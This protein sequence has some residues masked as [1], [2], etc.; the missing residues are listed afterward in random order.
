[1]GKRPARAAAISLAILAVTGFLLVRYVFGGPGTARPHPPALTAAAAVKALATFDKAFYVG[2]WHRGFYSKSTRTGLSRL[3]ERGGDDRDGRGLL[4]T[5]RR[6][7]LQAAGRRPVPRS[8]RAIRHPDGCTCTDPTSH[9]RIGQRA[10]DDIMWM[11]IA[12][13]RAY[14]ITGSA[15]YL[16]M[17]RWNFDHAYARAWS[18]ALGGGLWWRTANDR[19]GRTRRRTR[20]AVIAAGELYRAHQRPRLSC[21]GDG[22]LHMDASPPVRPSD[23]GRFYDIVA[24]ADDRRHQRSSSVGYTYNQGSFIGAADLLYA[25]TRRRI[26]YADALGALLYTRTHLTQDGIL[27]NDATEPDQ[28]AGGFKGVFARWALDLHAGQPHLRFDSWFRLNA[29]TGLVGAERRRP[30]RLGLAGQ[31]GRRAAVLL[32]LLIGRGHDGGRCWSLAPP[33]RHERPAA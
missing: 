14:T 2:S 32:G 24:P 28:D 12:F 33:G 22:A 1:M 31:D 17:A 23:S 26:Y 5:D 20:P 8:D 19:P 16:D 25:I 9:R 13:T 3:L 27:Q 30:R 21:P 18:E 6:P 29:D 11:A 10:N 7:R 4:Q 15:P